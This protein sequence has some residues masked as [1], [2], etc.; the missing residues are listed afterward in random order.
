MYFVKFQLLP[1]SIWF[2]LPTQPKSQRYTGSGTQRAARP[3]LI[4]WVG[5]TFWAPGAHIYEPLQVGSRMYIYIKLN[6]Q[7]RWA[8]V[9][10]IYIN[11]SLV[12]VCG[13]QS[14]QKR[15]TKRIVHHRRVCWGEQE[16][17][18]VRDAHSAINCFNDLK[19]PVTLKNF[20]KFTL[21]MRSWRVYS[22]LVRLPKMHIE[23]SVDIFCPLHSCAMKQWM[24]SLR[25]VHLIQISNQNSGGVWDSTKPIID[26]KLGRFGSNTSTTIDFVYPYIVNGRWKCAHHKLDLEMYANVVYKWLSAQSFSKRIEL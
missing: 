11:S 25:V 16:G 10:P 6:R 2:H 20:D 18:K 4:D 24:H 14:V 8:H 7:T 9:T 15:G 12:Y 22:R 13:A 1:P 3:Y 26:A 5:D 19:P 23:K 21:G 17:R